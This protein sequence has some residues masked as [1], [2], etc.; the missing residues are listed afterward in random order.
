MVYFALFH[1]ENLFS[2]CFRVVQCMFCFIV[3]SF[4]GSEDGLSKIRHQHVMTFFFFCHFVFSLWFYLSCVSVQCVVLFFS[5]SS[6]I[7][8]IQ[9]AQISVN[10][11]SA[12]LSKLDIQVEQTQNLLYPQNNL[13]D[14][15]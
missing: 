2:S 14:A 5:T 7:R 11:Q 10:L 9:V 1:L 15:W 3:Q 6:E 8:N 13:P 4:F 12:H